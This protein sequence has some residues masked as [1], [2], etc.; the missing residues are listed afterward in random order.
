MSSVDS[1]FSVAIYHDFALSKRHSGPSAIRAG[2][3]FLPCFQDTSLAGKNVY[4][5]LLGINPMLACRDCA[6]DALTDNAE[7]LARVLSSGSPLQGGKGADAIN[8]S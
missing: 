4:G 2:H 8:G 5:H 6:A 7:R 3:I 1:V